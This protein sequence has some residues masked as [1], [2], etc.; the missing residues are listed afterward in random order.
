MSSWTRD[1]SQ[2]IGFHTFAEIREYKLYHYDVVV[3]KLGATCFNNHGFQTSW[4]DI[5]TLCMYYT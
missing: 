1:Y 4:N 2:Y 3:A 5:F